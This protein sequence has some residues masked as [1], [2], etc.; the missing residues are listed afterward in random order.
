MAFK[1]T[2]GELKLSN[3]DVK[4]LEELSSSRTEKYSTVERSRILLMYYNNKSTNDIA[5]ALNIYKAKIYRTVNKALSSG[6]DAALNDKPRPG[7]PRVITDEARAYIIKTACTKPVDLRLPYELWTNRLL[8][9]YI[10]ENAPEEYNI[11]GISNGTVSKIL[12]KGNIKPHKIAYCEEK[13]DPDFE[14]K[15]REILHVYKDISMYKINNNDNN[16]ELYAFLSYDEKPGIQATGN[17][18]SDKNPDKN[19]SN[20]SRNHD[21]IRHG[22]LSLLAGIDLVTG[23]IIYTVE[24]KHRSIEFVKWLDSVDKYYPGDYKI[25]IIMDNHSIHKSKETQEYINK[26]PGRFKFVFTPVHAS[27]LNIIETMFS[28]MARSFLR[29]IRVNS[30][31]ELKSRIDNYFDGINREPTEFVWRYKMDYMPGG[32]KM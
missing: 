23:H 30:K 13:T 6:I 5:K 12:A 31:N 9:K 3:D 15:E 4:M 1:R 21:Y 7:K 2:K 19:H 29:G 14:T 32:I 11:S 10:R 26:K 18:Y 16:N 27:W 17:I 28:K 22:T 24:D 8:T 25:K 20:V